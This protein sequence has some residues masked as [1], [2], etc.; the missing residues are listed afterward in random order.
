MAVQQR[1][2]TWSPATAI[3]PRHGPSDWP[4][5]RRG[6]TSHRRASRESLWPPRNTRFRRFHCRVR[7]TKNTFTFTE[8]VQSIPRRPLLGMDADTLDVQLFDGHIEAW[9]LVVA[10]LLC[11]VITS[12]SVSA[13]GV[14]LPT[15]RHPSAPTELRASSSYLPL[16]KGVP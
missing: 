5:G 14:T 13:G 7:T 12:L 10:T 4:I 11:W 3:Y 2:A 15:S 9:R 16:T 1:A 6:K 8:T